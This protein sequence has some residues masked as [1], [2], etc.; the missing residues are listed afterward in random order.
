M[1]TIL[2]SIIVFFASF[3]LNAQNSV[4]TVL[5]AVEDNNTTL[6]ALKETANAQKL[7]NKTVLC[8][9]LF[10]RFLQLPSINFPLLI[11]TV[12]SIINTL[13]S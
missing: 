2:I 10:Q 11:S 6:K 8:S 9:L 13:V 12:S 5:K 4:V 3:S 1:K 7:E